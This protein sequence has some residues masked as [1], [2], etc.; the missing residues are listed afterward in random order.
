MLYYI[1][2][3]FYYAGIGS[4][5]TPLPILAYMIQLARHLRLHHHAHVYSG[6]APGADSAFELGGRECGTYFL[7]YASAFQRQQR[8]QYPTID[9]IPSSCYVVRGRHPIAR[10]IIQQHYIGPPFQSLRDSHQLLHTRNVCQI[11]GPECDTPVS[12]VVCY[13]PDGATQLSEFT[14]K[15]GGTRTAIRLAEVHGIPIWNLARPEHQKKLE[16]LFQLSDTFHQDVQKTIHYIQQHERD[17]ATLFPVL[18]RIQPSYAS[19]K[20]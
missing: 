10:T 14:P 8:T 6:S 3:T 16:S 17:Y 12:F 7:P 18:T 9:T 15:S 5:K 2:N 11:L 13:T 20:M 4:R 1:M 19:L